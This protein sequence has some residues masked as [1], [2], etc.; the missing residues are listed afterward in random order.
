MNFDR[1]TMKPPVIKEK[2][3]R[4]DPTP[5]T[6]RRD[7]GSRRLE[8]ESTVMNTLLNDRT[9]RG[10]SDDVLRSSSFRY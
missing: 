4:P 10:K 6:L 3:P 1:T 7:Y 5:A 2:L 9:K 8:R